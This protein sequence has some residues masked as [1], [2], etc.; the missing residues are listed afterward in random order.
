MRKTTP[1]PI[2]N[3]YELHRRFRYEDGKLFWRIR[4]ARRI[5]IGDR[6]GTYS[7]TGYR[8][9][10]I[11]RTSYLEHRIIYAMF[12]YGVSLDGLQIDHLNHII[13]DNRIENLE[14][15]TN[16]ENQHNRFPKGCRFVKGIG[17][18]RA[19][20][21]ANYKRIYLGCFDTEAEAHRA[22]LEAKLIHHPTA[23]HTARLL[24]ELA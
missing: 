11:N 2:P 13:D 3:S 6:A 14:L 21:R 10:H 1:I 17:K 16:S 23:P 19:D 20:I 5:Q 24:A 8:L 18:W 7:G 4:S 22:Y 12:N 15:G 9:T